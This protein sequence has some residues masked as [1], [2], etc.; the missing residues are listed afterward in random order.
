MITVGLSVRLGDWV[1]LV[2]AEVAE[3]RVL[4]TRLLKPDILA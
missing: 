2:A 3:L 4:S 1:M